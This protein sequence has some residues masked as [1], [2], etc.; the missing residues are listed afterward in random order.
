MAGGQQINTAQGAFGK[1]VTVALV[2]IGIAVSSGII[3]ANINGTVALIGQ[4]ITVSTGNPVPTHVRALVGQE[5]TSVRGTLTPGNL[6]PALVGFTI[7]A[8]TGFLSALGDDVTVTLSGVE[9]TFEQGFVERASEVLVGASIATA[10]GAVGKSTEVALTGIGLTLATGTLAPGIEANDTY[11]QTSSGTVSADISVE[12]FG[13]EMLFETGEIGA[14]FG[15]LGLEI[16][17]SAGTLSPDLAIPLLG[18]AIAVE[19]GT[20]GAPGFASLT[21]VEITTQ[22]GTMYLTE[23]RTYALTGQEIAVQQGNVVT[24]A[25]AFVIGQQI[26]VSQENIGPREVTLVGIEIAVEQ[27]ILSPPAVVGDERPPSLEWIIAKP[28]KP[29]KK[30]RKTFKQEL[31]EVLGDMKLPE[32]LT[33]GTGV[34]ESIIEAKV[35]EYVKTELED[36]DEALLLASL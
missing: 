34:P 31:E 32:G 11:I 25:L 36:E 17:V 28:E 14:N 20:L 10:T 30:D 21:G 4:Q 35:E 26:T 13:L 7:Q 3:T 5:L 19:Q 2:G 9:I 22:T 15:L 24:S 8:S 18:Q 23:D 16:P 12:L 27:G 6:Q 29:K 1:G 33:V